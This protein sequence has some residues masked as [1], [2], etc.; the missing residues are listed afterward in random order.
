MSKI[1][2]DKTSICI[3]I[4]SVLFLTSCSAP[5]A[6][7]FDITVLNTNAFNDF[8][9]P[10]LAR[11]INDETKEFPDIPSSKKKGDEA[12]NTIKNKILYIE[13]SLEKIKKLDASGDEQKEIKDLSIALY[14]MVIPVFKNEY[15]A[16]AKLCDAQ[17]NQGAKDALVN[18]IDLKYRARFEKSYDALMQKGKTYAAENDIQV[19]WGQ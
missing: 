8:A 4:L 3:L 12:A 13:Q 7:F 9:S 5:P 14:E 15:M 11:H 10:D 1:I 2:F 16:Y 18:E 17:G 19:N 6:E